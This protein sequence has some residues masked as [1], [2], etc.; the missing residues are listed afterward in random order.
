[1]IV[2]SLF[3]ITD[4]LAAGPLV[5]QEETVQPDEVQNI[6]ERTALVHPSRTVEDVARAVEMAKLQ[7]Q[8]SEEGDKLIAAVEKLLK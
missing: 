4:V 7:I 2:N 8:N 5:G 1:L 6:I 3:S